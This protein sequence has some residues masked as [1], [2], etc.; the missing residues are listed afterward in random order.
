MSV[1]KTHSRCP[2]AVVQQEQG[3]STLLFTWIVVLIHMH[4]SKH[5]DQAKKV[6]VKNGYMN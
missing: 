5:F 3:S 4:I 6:S 1:F 2:H